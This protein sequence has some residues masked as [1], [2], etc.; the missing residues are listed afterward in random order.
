MR[1]V[2]VESWL[3][4]GVACLEVDD[5]GGGALLM[6]GRGPVSTPTGQADGRATT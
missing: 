6:V 5:V 2:D 3:E 4:L 1:G